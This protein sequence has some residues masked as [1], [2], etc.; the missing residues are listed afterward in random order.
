MGYN[1]KK[2]RVLKKDQIFEGYQLQFGSYPNSKPLNHRIYGLGIFPKTKC[3]RYTK[4][5]HFRQFLNQK[6]EGEQVRARLHI[7]GRRVKRDCLKF[8]RFKNL[9]ASVEASEEEQES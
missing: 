8:S 3:Y 2:G 1:L 7:S 5:S 4:S 9:A 6:Q